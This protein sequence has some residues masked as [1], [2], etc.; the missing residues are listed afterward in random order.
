M[1]ARLFDELEAAGG[2]FGQ[3]G[4]GGRLGGVVAG[5]A[6]VGVVLGFVHAQVGGDAKSFHFQGIF[7]EDG[8]ADAGADEDGVIAELKRFAEQFE[9]RAADVHRFGAA[10]GLFEDDGEFIAAGAGHGIG[11]AHARGEERGYALKHYVAD[12]MAE[13]IVDVL[14]RVEIDDKERPSSTGNG[15]RARGRR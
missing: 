13:G 2:A 8:D 11:A 12:V 6:G 14:E 9:E 4:A 5:E 7:R 3:D 15:G 1:E 10:G